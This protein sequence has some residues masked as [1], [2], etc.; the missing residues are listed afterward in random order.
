MPLLDTFSF[1]WFDF[2]FND[3]IGELDDILELEFAFELLAVLTSDELFS[4]WSTNDVAFT[5][6]FDDGRDKEFSRVGLRNCSECDW[7]NELFGDEHESSFL[8]IGGVLGRVSA[9]AWVWYRWKKK[10]VD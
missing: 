10:K 3:E 5:G 7:R 6:V 1:W 8:I 2:S 9:K 4:R